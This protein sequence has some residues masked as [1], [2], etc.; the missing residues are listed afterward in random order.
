[1]LVFSYRTTATACLVLFVALSICLML[2]P[3]FL[4]MLFGAE[5]SSVANIMLRRASVL[6]FGLAILMFFTKDNP[7]DANQTAI[8]RALTVTFFA[9]AVLGVAEWARGALGAGIWLA[10]LTEI[11]FGF[12]LLRTR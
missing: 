2:F 5:P 1:M 6:F 4:T 8:I 10:I 3:S 7:A 11:A 12:M 9:L